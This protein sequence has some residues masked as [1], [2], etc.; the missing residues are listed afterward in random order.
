[1][2][3]RK[4]RGRQCG[5]GIGTL[6]HVG[7]QSPTGSRNKNNTR[8]GSRCYGRS[9]EDVKK[10]PNS[11][12]KNS[13]IRP[14]HLHTLK[15]YA[16]MLRSKLNAKQIRALNSVHTHKRAAIIPLTRIK[17]ED[18]LAPS[19]HT[20][21]FPSSWQPSGSDFF[22]CVHIFDFYHIKLVWQG[23]LCVMAWREIGRK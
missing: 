13:V 3:R 7:S 20:S 21:A 11:R 15:P 18:S 8:L 9:G 23:N 22:F 17:K 19:W 14:Q 5:K 4:T 2:K 16:P 12:K 10:S 6:R 1:M